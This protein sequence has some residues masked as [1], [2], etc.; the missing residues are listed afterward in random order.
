MKQDRIQQVFSPSRQRI[1]LVAVSIL[2]QAAILVVA[3]GMFSQYFGWFYLACLC[4][5]AIASLEISMKKTKLAY[6]IAWIIPILLVP[7]VGGL[8]YFALGGGRKPHYQK[9]DVL[10]LFRRHLSPTPPSRPITS[11][12]MAS[13]RPIW[14]PR[15]AIT[16]PARTSFPRCWRLWSRRSGT[17]SWNISSSRKNPPCGGR[18]WRFWSARQ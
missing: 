14:A 10:R 4:I 7:V 11:S 18:C 16:P 15:P 3:L 9:T 5:S 17:F 8:M 1:S 12:N 6:K 2:L 13:S